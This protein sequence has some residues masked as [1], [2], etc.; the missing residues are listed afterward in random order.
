MACVVA[1]ATV[2]TCLLTASDRQKRRSFSRWSEKPSRPAAR[3]DTRV[4]QGRGS[5]AYRRT[6]VV[7]AAFSTPAGSEK[8]RREPQWLKPS[9]VP[10]RI[11][12]CSVWAGRTEMPLIFSL[13]RDSKGFSTLSPIKGC[14][15]QGTA[16]STG[17]LRVN[18]RV[19]GTVSAANG[20]A[21]RTSRCQTPNC[22][23]NM[24]SASEASDQKIRVAPMN[25]RL[26]ISLSIGACAG[27]TDLA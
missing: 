3:S 25:A 4:T 17:T 6:A 20:P 21:S 1:A 15:H 7:V 12:T 14:L 24:T 9:L 19:A 8:M 27:A 18:A 22:I 11:D 16:C 5:T 13:R 10:V 23:A 26:L 2:D